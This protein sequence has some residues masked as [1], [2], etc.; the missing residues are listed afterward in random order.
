MGDDIVHSSSLLE[1]GFFPEILIQMTNKIR[2]KIRIAVMSAVPY[3]PKISNEMKKSI[4]CIIATRSKNG[5][6]SILLLIDSLTFVLEINDWAALTPLVYTG[7]N[8]GIQRNT[9]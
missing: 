1:K 2:I 6:L 3:R 7:V 5:M 4:G 8:R 9:S